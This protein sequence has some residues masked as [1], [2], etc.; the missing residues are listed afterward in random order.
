MPDNLRI[1]GTGDESILEFGRDHSEK[2]QQLSR[3]VLSALYM[4][5]RSVKM[6]DPDNA[7]FEQPADAAAGHAQP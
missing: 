4:L 5:V 3:S 2:L 7:V 6:Y 1:S